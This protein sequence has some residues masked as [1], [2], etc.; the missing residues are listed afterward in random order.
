L[1]RSDRAPRAAPASAHSQSPTVQLEHR[2]RHLDQHRSA[3]PERISWK[4][5]RIRSA[6]PAPSVPAPTICWPETAAWNIGRTCCRARRPPATISKGTFPHGLRDA[7][8]ILDAWPPAANTPLRLPRMMRIAVGNADADP[9]CRHRIFP[10][11]IAAQASISGLRIA[12]RGTRALALENF[13]DECGAIHGS[14]PS[15]SG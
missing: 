15:F 7:E 14:C 13:S 8:G 2:I 10:T 1:R 6:V 11:S 5:R 9:S 12:G 4:A 3:L